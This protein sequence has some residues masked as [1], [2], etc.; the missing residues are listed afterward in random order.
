MLWDQ[1]ELGLI[2]GEESSRLKEI[3]KMMT[4]LVETEKI[5][6]KYQMMMVTMLKEFQMGMKMMNS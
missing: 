5:L 1:H 3:F 4:T 6:I 2:K